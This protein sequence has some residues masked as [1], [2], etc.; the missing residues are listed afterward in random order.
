MRG[1]I[2]LGVTLCVLGLTAQGCKAD[3]D[4]SS[5]SEDKAEV[6]LGVLNISPENDQLVFQYYSPETGKPVVV[7]EPD[8]VPEGSRKNVMIMFSG[9]A[10]E[11]LPAQALVLADL[12]NVDEE[13]GRYSARIVNRYDSRFASLPTAQGTATERGVGITLYTAPG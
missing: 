11:R 9:D 3:N 8:K 12:D 7:T 4:K 1:K 13:T 10:R 6:K 2:L 5:G